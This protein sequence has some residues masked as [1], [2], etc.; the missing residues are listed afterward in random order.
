MRIIAGTRKGFRL[1]MHKGL[2][3][4]PTADRVRESV[5]STL[6]TR[7]SGARFLDLFAGSGAI[8]IEALSRGAKD[9]VF[10]EKDRQALQTLKKN[11][12]I[13]KFGKES[14]VLA[15]D[16][17]QAIGLLKEEHFDIVYVDPPYETDYYFDTL[18]LLAEYD[19][20]T[21]N[22]VIV[23]ESGKKSLPIENTEPFIVMKTKH[24]GDSSVYYL[25]RRP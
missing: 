8:G 6:Q 11:L 4:R 17:R 14:R 7:I 5:F 23:C 19:I 22:G 10:V 12:Q 13:T 16:F 9:C 2:R 15:M 24:Y 3:T 21:K 18:T 25:Q 20:I 1:H